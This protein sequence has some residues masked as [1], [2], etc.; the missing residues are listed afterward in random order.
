MSVAGDFAKMATDL[1]GYFKRTNMTYRVITPGAI[2][3]T[4]GIVSAQTFT[5]YSFVGALVKYTD[6]LVDG[7][8]IRAGD[9]CCYIPLSGLQFDPKVGDRVL[10][11]EADYNVIDTAQSEIDDTGIVQRLQLRR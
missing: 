4:T 7:T 9:R 2:N 8:T 3:E 11:P 10:T 1:V 6:N 5:D